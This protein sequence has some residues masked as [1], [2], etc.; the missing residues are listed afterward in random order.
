MRFQKV[1][2]EARRLVARA[3]AVGRENA[4]VRRA[5]V[6]SLESSRRSRELRIRGVV[7]GVLDGS[8]PSVRSRSANGEAASALRQLADELDA[9]APAQAGRPAPDEAGSEARLTSRQLEV[10]RLLADG[11]GTDEI[12]HKL[13]LSPSTVRNH[14]MAILRA[15]DS[16]SRLQAVARARD[17]GLL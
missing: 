2:E 6:A 16:H 4:R 11:V 1:R 15:L 8:Q 9:L 5:L 10:L 7:D 12:A 3:E 17:R 13:W 14:V